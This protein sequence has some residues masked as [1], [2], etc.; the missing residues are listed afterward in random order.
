MPRRKSS[1]PPSYFGWRY[2]WWM[3]Y[4]NAITILMIV[5]GGISAITL[6]P[7]LVSHSTFH[8]MLIAN[9]VLCLTLAQIKRDH[10]PPKRG[11][12]R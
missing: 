11:R 12:K 4:K 2:I 3:A 8:W 10:P 5:Q 1:A 7:S 9:S 6:D